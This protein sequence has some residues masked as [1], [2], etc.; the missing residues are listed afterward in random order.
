MNR[1]GGFGDFE[2]TVDSISLKD[3]T[4]SKDEILEN[5]AAVKN[6][7]EFLNG[8]LITVPGLEPLFDYEKEAANVPFPGPGMGAM[9]TGFARFAKV[10]DGII[11]TGSNVLEKEAIEACGE[12]AEVWT[13]GLQ[14]NPRAWGKGCVLGEGSVKEFLG[15]KGKGEVLY[16][17]F[18]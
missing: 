18:G 4:R 5:V 17:S 3:T 6:G 11:A 7:T 2:T 10:A 9:I 8:T 13:V 15:K 1:L 16:V 12:Y 14:V